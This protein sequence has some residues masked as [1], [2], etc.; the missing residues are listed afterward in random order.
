M[1]LSQHAHPAR[2]QTQ[3]DPSRAARVMRRVMIPAQRD[4]PPRQPR[5]D[6]LP[7]EVLPADRVVRVD[8]ADRRD[9][10]VLARHARAALDGGAERC[11]RLV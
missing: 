8:A 11:A 5:I 7:L 6:A 1:L 2:K 9:A 4:R 3:R 10:I